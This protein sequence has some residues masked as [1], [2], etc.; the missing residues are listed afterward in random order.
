MTWIFISL[1]MYI[2][3]HTVVS[4][5]VFGEEDQCIL[6]CHCQQGSCNKSSGKCDSGTCKLDP[7]LSA[8]NPEINGRNYW[9]GEACQIGNI[10]AG[11]P[12]YQ[13]ATYYNPGFKINAT[14]EKAIDGNISSYAYSRSSS[15][16]DAYW[17]VDLQSVHVIMKAYII[18]NSLGNGLITL[19]NYTVYVGNDSDV[20]SHDLCGQVAV[21]L[22]P[23]YR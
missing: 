1:S 13:I 22:I 23:T 11:K 18:A 3:P 8:H 15:P 17:M 9:T 10:A 4:I 5:C 20:F 6:P 12:T 7:L 19:E 16:S 2:L 14:S 21:P